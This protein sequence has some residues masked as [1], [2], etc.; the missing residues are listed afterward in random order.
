MASSTNFAAITGDWLE[1]FSTKGRVEREAAEL[2]MFR[3]RMKQY[4]FE[5]KYVLYAMHSKEP[6]DA[7]PPCRDNG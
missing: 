2:A 4:G 6:M 3:A 7:A 1:G 5:G